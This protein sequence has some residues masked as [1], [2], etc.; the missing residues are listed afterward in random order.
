MRMIL[1][2]LTRRHLMALAIGGTILSAGPLPVSQVYAA[3]PVEV[4]ALFTGAVT[5]GNW[6]KPGYAAFDKMVKKYNFKPSYIENATYEKAPAILRQLASRGVKMIICHSSGYSAAIQEVA[7]EFPDTQFVLYSYA[8]STGD[9][10]NY[11]AWSVNWDEYGF[12]TGAVAA[13]SSKNKHIAIISGEEIPSA[14]RAQEFTIKGAK[15]LVGDIQVDTVYT[16]SFTDVAK[17]KEIATGV[18]ARGADVLLPS[19][20]LADVGTQ[21]AA[22][23]EE[24]HTIGAYMDQSAAYPNAVITSTVLNFDKAYDQMGEL[25]TAGKLGGKVYQM[26]LAHDGWTLFKPFKHVDTKV[27]ADV[28]AT[29]AKIAKGELDVTK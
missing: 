13:A 22:D 10:K 11:T 28:F 16:G 9:L 2:S 3:D 21:Q 8:A 7:K 19:A 20:D 25:M 18:I 15:S 6:D 1:Q 27:E 12:I 29:M 14:K 4:A 24:A 23:E 5:Q 26:D 17:A